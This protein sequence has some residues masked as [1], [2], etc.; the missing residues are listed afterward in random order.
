MR[1]SSADVSSFVRV[2]RADAHFDLVL[3]A[4][5]ID[6]KNDW[7]G[8]VEGNVVQSGLGHVE[9]EKGLDR[10][11]SSLRLVQVSKRNENE[12]NMPKVHL[13]CKKGIMEDDK[14]I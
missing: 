11:K 10:K 8:G 14:A 1:V 7:G 12:E 3:N 5:F 2:V 9:D 4:E 13:N 6:G